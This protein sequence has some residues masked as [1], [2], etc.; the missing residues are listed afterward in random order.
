MSSGPPP[1]SFPA[2]CRRESGRRRADKLR[3]VARL[4]IAL[5]AVLLLTAA[6]FVMR[7]GSTIEGDLLAASADTL[8]VRPY[9][10]GL[11]A[12]PIANVQRVELGPPGRHR[13]AFW[14]EEARASSGDA[15]AATGLPDAF[16]AGPNPRAWSPVGP[17]PAT[18]EVWIGE[19]LYLDRVAL[20]MNAGGS[21][22][23]RVAVVR[24][25]G[26]EIVVWEGQ[27]EADGIPGWV[28]ISF[29]PVTAPIST[30][31]LEFDYGVIAPAVDTVRLEGWQ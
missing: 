5:L 21:S 3:Y 8:F 25:D 11:L 4:L 18:L 2:A 6:T 22:L 15:S 16:R 20:L 29:R 13:V 10:G 7:D 24:P 26:I 1:G 23:V 30:V 12:L 19:A 17:G 14:A 27:S 28:E 9:G 31:R